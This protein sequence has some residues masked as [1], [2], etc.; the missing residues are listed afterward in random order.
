MEISLT[1]R[2]IYRIIVPLFVLG[3]VW[4]GGGLAS[5]G[6]AKTSYSSSITFLAKPHSVYTANASVEVIGLLHEIPIP[7]RLLAPPELFHVRIGKATLS[8]QGFGTEDDPQ[9]LLEFYEEALPIFGWTKLL[10][11][12]Q[13]QQ[14]SL[15]DQLSLTIQN[16]PNT[17]RQKQLQSL[18]QAYR[19][20]AMALRRQIFATRGNERVIVNLLPMGK[21]TAVFLNR[22]AGDEAPWVGQQQHATNICCSEEGID[23]N[24]VDLP[25][26]IP[27]Y[28]NGRVISQAQSTASSQTLLLVTQDPIEQVRSYYQEQMVRSGWKRREVQGAGY[29]VQEEKRL[30]FERLGRYCAIE[31]RSSN[32]NTLVKLELGSVQ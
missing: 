23:E 18:V 28:P 3:S 6:E 9:T 29:K 19:N 16:E 24:T 1:L 10:L 7:N 20:T 2:G 5:A 12:W 11:P 26:S 15:I 14:L 22:W 4:Q 13:A 32:H 31:L 25:V 27:R 21:G 30:E 8:V 17:N